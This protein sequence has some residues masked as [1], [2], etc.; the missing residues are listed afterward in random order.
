MGWTG[1]LIT[2]CFSA[3]AG[4]GLDSSS[5][6][7]IADLGNDRIQ[8]F[9]PDGTFI[10]KW[11]TLGTANGQF[12]SPE[13]I[14]TNPSTNNVYVADRDNNRVQ[15]FTSGGGFIR[16]WGEFGEVRIQTDA[17]FGVLR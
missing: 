5:N 15:E 10:R 13:G 12:D 14:G 3:A 8:K 2:D 4:I 7:Y 1:Q 9:K 17:V 6:V 16:S 11:G